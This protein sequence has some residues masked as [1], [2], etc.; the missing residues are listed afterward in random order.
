MRREM[1][2]L[3]LLVGAPMVMGCGTLIAPGPDLVPV[4]S[5]PSGAVVRLDDREAGRTPCIV[6]VPRNS[7]G[8]FTFDLAGFEIARVDR[9]KVPNG[10]ALF[11]VLGGYLTL[12]VFFAIDF[13]SGNLGKYSTEELRV[14]LKP[15]PGARPPG[16]LRF[17]R[18]R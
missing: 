11:N 15:L 8:V 17:R 6:A 5:D 13:F 9:D 2:V 16:C 1:A 14:T 12:P 3:V 10:A 4:S 7:E 18:W